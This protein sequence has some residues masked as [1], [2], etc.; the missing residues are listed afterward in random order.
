MLQGESKLIIKCP[1]CGTP[2]SVKNI[3]GIEKK[4]LTCPVCKCKAPF[5]SFKRVVKNNH[6]DTT[7][8]EKK[9]TGFS[10]DS[11]DET[12]H[13]LYGKDNKNVIGVLRLSSVNKEYRLKAGRNVIGRQAQASTADIQI[14]TGEGRRMSREHLVIDVKYVAGKGYVHCASLYK[15]KVNDTFINDVKLEYGDCVVLAD[16]DHLLLPDEEIY[17]RIPDPDATQVL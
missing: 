15:Q 8:P 7:Y 14:N 16:G 9:E 1:F 4:N 10:K 13:T 11:T 5:T 17:F 2:L 6:E 3:P 12:E